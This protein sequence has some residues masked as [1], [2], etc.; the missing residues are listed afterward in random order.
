MSHRDYT[1]IIKILE[2]IKIGLKMIQ[3]TN[4]ENFLKDE[5]TKRATAMTVIN[6]G[7]LVKNI[8]DET[9][10]KYPK[11]QWKAIAGMRD[12]AA[13][14]YQTLR[15]EDVFYTMNVDLVVLK[16]GIVAIIPSLLTTFIANGLWID[17]SFQFHIVLFI[18]TGMGGLLLGLLD[19]KIFNGS[20]IPSVFLHG[21]GNFIS[22]LFVMF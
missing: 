4:I 7:E 14:K 15:M 3:N 19:E 20:I 12:I 2:E 10:R 9:R 22:N 16:G 21:L 11:I 5:V 17:I 18:F 8:T 1:I 13:H 6:I